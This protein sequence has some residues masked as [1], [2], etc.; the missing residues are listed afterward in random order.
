MTEFDP[1]R[2][3]RNLLVILRIDVMGGGGYLLHCW[4]LEIR[5][6]SDQVVWASFSWC[7]KV[8]SPTLT[9]S[10]FVPYSFSNF[11]AAVGK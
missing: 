7:G 3:C 9:A 4:V 6:H 2:L 10:G 8:S 5:R 1:S 11:A